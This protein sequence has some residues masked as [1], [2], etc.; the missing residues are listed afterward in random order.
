MGQ[1]APNGIAICTAPEYKEIVPMKKMVVTDYF[2]D[3]K[4]NKVSPKEY[5]M[6]PDTPEESEVSVKFED[7]GQ[8]RTSFL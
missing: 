6:G 4:G 7:A 1:P 5:G 3:E 2:L 8:G